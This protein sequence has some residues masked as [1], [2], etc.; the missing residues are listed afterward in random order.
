MS[1]TTVDLVRHHL[2]AA[3]PF[4]EQVIDQPVLLRGTDSITFFAGQVDESSVRVKSVQSNQ[5]LRK[6]V[7]IN[8]GAVSTGTLP[9]VRGSVVVASDSSLGTIYTENKDYIIDYTTADLYLKTGGSLTAGMNVTVWYQQ[10]YVYQSG[11][12]YHLNYEQGTI[13]RV[14]GGDIADKETVLLDYTPIY[15]SYT[16]E[17]LSSAVLEANNLVERE[18]DPDRMFGADPVLQTVATCRALAII[19]RT[20]AARE[21]SSLRGGDRSAAAWM[22]LADIY[23][24]Q[25]QRLLASFRPPYDN[26]SSPVH[27]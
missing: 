8:T 2:T 14:T 22:K 20:A 27:S 1:Y 10:Y 23:A 16:E 25:S 12:D 17:I 24:E 18:V 4:Q 15:S 21:L 9:I 3:F 11:S 19:C 6:Q 7:T 13:R 26:P 5:P